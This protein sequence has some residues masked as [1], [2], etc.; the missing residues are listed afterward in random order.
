MLSSF[1]TR[2]RS[3]IWFL[4]F[5][6]LLYST[7][8][9][10]EILSR[11]ELR[12]FLSE[13]QAEEGDPPPDIPPETEA[14]PPPQQIQTLGLSSQSENDLDRVTPSVSFNV[15]DFT[16]GVHLSY[17]IVVPP[18]R[19]GLAP[20][21]S[22]SYSS[23]AGNGWIGVGWDLSVGFIQRRGPKRAVPKYDSTDKFELQMGGSPQELV[24]IPGTNEYRLK[25]EGASL[26]INYLSSSNSWE[27]YDKSGLKHKDRTESIHS[28]GYLSLVS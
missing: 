27:V 22:L 14:P 6:F 13:A 7:P 18:A 3:L 24:S 25:I 16:G 20:N 19:N 8:P 23:S 11:Y 1:T 5:T 4:I 21:L 26:K 10:I 2:F 15:D 12:I 9:Y 28:I 17:P